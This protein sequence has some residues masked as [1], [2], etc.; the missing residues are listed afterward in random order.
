MSH[1]T[2]RKLELQVVSC[3]MALETLDL[4]NNKL[5]QTEYPE[6]GM[7]H[8]L[9]TLASVQCLNLAQNMLIKL[10]DVVV[11]FGGLR[12]L[13]LTNNKCASFCCLLS[14]AGNYL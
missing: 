6:G 7:A 13:D 8:Q 4:E 9:A 12:I 11:G 10:P 5:G 3:M 1:G 14:A 2:D